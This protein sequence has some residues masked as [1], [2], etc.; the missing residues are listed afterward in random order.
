MASEKK[1]VAGTVSIHL[2]TVTVVCDSFSGAYGRDSDR[3]M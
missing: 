2:G 1:K 3:L